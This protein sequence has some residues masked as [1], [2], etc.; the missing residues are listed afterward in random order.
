M[1]IVEGKTQ[2]DLSDEGF[3]ALAAGF[4]RVA[5]DVGTGDGRFVLRKARAEPE[6]LCLGLDAVAEAMADSA[7]RAR[8][9]PAKGGA[10][11]ALFL[12][13]PVEALPPGLRGICDTVTVNYP[14]GSLLQAVTTPILEVLADLAACAKPGAELSV[15][16]NLAPFEDQDQRARLGLAPL[17]SEIAQERLL[18]AY[19]AAGVALERIETVRGDLPERTAWGSKLV[20]GSGRSTLVLDGIRL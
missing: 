14:W 9:K 3:V 12:V 11:N 16:I 10:P 15:L 7:R 13:A 4:R 18:P 2:R 1:R 17:D 19:R 8:A 6:T 5:L 20:K